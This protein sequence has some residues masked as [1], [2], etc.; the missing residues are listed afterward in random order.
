MNPADLKRLSS[1]IVAKRKLLGLSQRELA[2]RSGLS[3][4]RH[5]ENGRVRPRTESLQAIASA[6]DIELSEL[7]VAGN[8]EPPKE[9]PQLMPYLRS[10]Y[11]D[12]DD[13]AVA[14]INTFVE[15]LRKRHGA[16]GPVDHEDEV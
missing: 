5:I 4:V 9:L 14:E 7:L 13:A 11:D 1:Y 8:Y 16:A 10:K 12:L 2:R 6:L 15:Q 3:D